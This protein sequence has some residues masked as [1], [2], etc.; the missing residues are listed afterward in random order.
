MSP[1]RV[2]IFLCVYCLLLSQDMF[3]GSCLLQAP[4]SHLTCDGGFKLEA[5][6]TIACQKVVTGVG[7][8]GIGVQSHARRK[9]QTTSELTEQRGSNLTPSPADPD[10]AADVNLCG[11]AA[12]MQ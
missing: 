3:W 9:T 5:E 8:L 2:D 4:V 7:V 11:L 1:E 10:V 6:R 12:K